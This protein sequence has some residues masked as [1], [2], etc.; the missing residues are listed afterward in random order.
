MNRNQDSRTAILP[1]FEFH[2]VALEGIFILF[3]FVAAM[4]LFP[5]KAHA[6]ILPQKAIWE[7][8]INAFEKRDRIDPPPQNAVLF[9][10][11]SSFRK[12][13]AMA[14]DFP[15][16][17][18]INRGFGGS[19]IDDST[20]FAERIIFPYHP[21]IIVLY[22]GDNDL[23][24]GK[25]PDYVAA[26]Y[27]NFVSVVH[28]RLPQTHI[29]FV[30]IKPSL[31]RWKLK[32]EIV[33]TNRR[34]AAI[35]GNYLAFVDVYPQMLGPDGKPRKDLLLSDGLHPSEKCYRLWASLIRPYLN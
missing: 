12:W 19:Q 25:T 1:R 7:P 24:A 13:T 8:E 6:Q 30:S 31:A 29:V 34:I 5:T 20:S 18:V 35:H 3:L 23:A 22:A 2:G 17:Q 33:E 28:Q 14:E 9:I 27:T 26:E 32:N 10:G 15:G 4:V 21:R 11:S 16:I